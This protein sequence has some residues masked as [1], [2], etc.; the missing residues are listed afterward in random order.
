[1]I[2]GI[3]RH[4]SFLLPNPKP[5]SADHR[6]YSC[7]NHPEAD[8]SSCFCHNLHP[9]VEICC[10]C[11]GVLPSDCAEIYLSCRCC[12]KWDFL[13]QRHH[14]LV[15]V[16]NYCL[17]DK[18]DANLAS[19]CVSSYLLQ[20]H[21]TL[22]G[23]ACCLPDWM[24]AN[25]ASDCVKSYLSLPDWMDAN[26]ASDCVKSY[27]LG[28]INLPVDTHGTKQNSNGIEP[29]ARVPVN[30]VHPNKPSFLSD[31]SVRCTHGCKPPD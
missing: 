31:S 2:A 22:V 1:M 13:L 14:H 24:D 5:L 28:N 29:D 9:D 19:D 10:L 11:D 26:L 7:N 15:G 16:A 4:R 23:V 27:L 30:A 18:M 25:L 17:P 20:M 21:Y 6:S 8:R 12:S 3:A